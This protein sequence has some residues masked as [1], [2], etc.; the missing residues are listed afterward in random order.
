MKIGTID[1]IVQQLWTELSGEIKHKFDLHVST[2]ELSIQ[3]ID[4]DDCDIDSLIATSIVEESIAINRKAHDQYGILKAVIAREVMYNAIPTDFIDTIAADDIA[5]EYGRQH[6]DSQHEQIWIDKWKEVNPPRK[7]SKGYPY[8]P[9]ESLQVL[10]K[11]RGSKGFADLLASVKKM[12]KYRIIPDFDDWAL[13]LYRYIMNTSAHL[14]MMECFV[15]DALMKSSN[16]TI[17]VISDRLRHSPQWTRKI[18]KS[19]KKRDILTEFEYVVLSK[20]GIRLYNIII[21]PPKDSQ[22][23]VSFLLRWCPFVYSTAPILTGNGGILATLCIPNNYEN[24]RYLGVLKNKARTYNL[25]VQ[26][27]ERFKAATLLNFDDYNHEAGRWDINWGVLQMESE[28]MQRDDLAIV[29]PQIH[30]SSPSE[31]LELDSLDLKILDLFQRGYKTIRELREQLESRNET[32][33][34]H[35]RKLRALDVIRKFWDV[36]HIGLVEEVIITSENPEI[37]HC[38]SALGLRLPRCNIEYDQKEN[39]LMRVQVPP[40]G[41]YGLIR[42]LSGLQPRPKPILVGNRLWGSWNLTNWLDDWNLET[43]KWMKTK[44]DTSRWIQSME[45]GPKSRT[46]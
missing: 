34:Q 12:A 32:I 28:M 1:E 7:T 22:I 2:N 14:K 3:I 40:G 37:V 4:N 15:I 18:I 44:N 16:E 46:G 31:D 13:F 35:V 30:Y 17:E 8:K 9:Q 24:I 29:Y 45:Q 38:V 6:I 19:L 43:G 25:D 26:I 5:W 11:L 23:D 42:A 39:L 33:I 10:E 21:E 27:F 20:I 41:T 36:Q